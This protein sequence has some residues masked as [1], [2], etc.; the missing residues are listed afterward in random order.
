MVA[1][2]SCWIEP[3]GPPSGGGL[4]DEG[5]TFHVRLCQSQ[6]ASDGGQP[7]LSGYVQSA[8]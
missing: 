7:V 3:Q 2:C 1:A 8:G 5:V 4:H 6:A